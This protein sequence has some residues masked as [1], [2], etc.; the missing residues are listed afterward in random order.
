[1]LFSNSNVRSSAIVA[2]SLSSSLLGC[3]QA[4]PSQEAVGSEGQALGS[5]DLTA[6]YTGAIADTR[7]WLVEWK[8]PQIMNANQANGAIGQWYFQFESGLWSG[9]QGW[10]V[11]YFGDDDGTADSSPS[12]DH[13]WGSGGFCNFGPLAQ[14]Q[15]VVFKYERCTASHVAS[16][17]GTLH[18]LYVD[19]KDGAGYHYIAATAIKNA[20]M[21]THDIENWRD[22]G[23]I[24]PDISCTNPTRM[25]R[26]QLKNPAGSWVNITGSSSWTFEQTAPYAFQ[27]KKL[28]TSPASW[29]SCTPQDSNGDGL[30]AEY[31]NNV[32]LTGTPALVRVD[33]RLEFDWGTGAPAP[34]IGADFFSVRW[35]GQVQPRYSETYTFSTTGD[36]GMRLWVNNVQLVNDWNIHPPTENSGT[37]SLVAG[38]QYSIKVEYFENDGGALA[39]LAWS[40]PSQA[41]EII[42][43]GH[44]FSTAGGGGSTCA[45]AYAQSNCLSYVQGARVSNLGHNW[46]CANGN[47]ANCATTSSCAPGASGCPWGVVWTDQ[48]TCQ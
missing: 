14:G 36:D 38:T 21:Y 33:P 44:L 45:T 25:V 26:Q 15:Q 4:P 23:L 5:Y 16:V 2:L 32:N 11:Y 43:R 12:C 47:C 18:C 24:T 30:H 22:D 28:T 40:S 31:F 7:G 48:G 6:H 19:L 34:S 1:M 42:P 10:S 29:E 46:V 13:T 9:P 35:T 20:E 27:N 17:N 39:K 3:G 37:I 8:I 41:K